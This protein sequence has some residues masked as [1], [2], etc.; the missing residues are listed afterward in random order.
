MPF[1]LAGLFASTGNVKRTGEYLRN[2]GREGFKNWWRISAEKE[3]DQVRGDPRVMKFSCFTGSSGP[4][5]R[6]D[7]R[8]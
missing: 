1:V 4:E 2:A 7:D 6:R 8:S 3:F 5:R